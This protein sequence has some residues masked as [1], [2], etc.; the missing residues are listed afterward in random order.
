[1]APK[2]FGELGQATVCL[3]AC[4]RRRPRLC[5]PPNSARGR[6]FFAKMTYKNNR[7]RSKTMK[8]GTCRI[9]VIL[10]PSV[11]GGSQFSHSLGI[12]GAEVTGTTSSSIQCQP[13]GVCPHPDPLQ[14]GA[15][16]HPKCTFKGAL[17]PPQPRIP[18]CAME[19]TSPSLFHSQGS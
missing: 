18:A 19:V 10:S 3:G 9:R 5:P 11:K 12:S 17:N 14:H 16:P 15:P 6:S 1:M 2:V 8:E 13:V 7:R 4:I